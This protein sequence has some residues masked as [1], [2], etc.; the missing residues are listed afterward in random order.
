MK[1]GVVKKYFQDKG[2]GFIKPDD[3]GDDVFVHIKQLEKSN[4]NGLKEGQ[5]VGFDI[6]VNQETGK[7]AA[8]K[9]QLCR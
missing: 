5:R 4:L 7:S 6:T 3:G 9:I 2:Y 8:T 1:L